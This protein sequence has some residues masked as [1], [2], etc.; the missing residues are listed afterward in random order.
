MLGILGVGA[1]QRPSQA[2]ADQG[3]FA[4]AGSGCGVFA[5]VESVAPALVCGASA[6]RSF[7]SAA[8]AGATPACIVGIVAKAGF[9]RVTLWLSTQ[10]FMRAPGRE[11]GSGVDLT[12]GGRLVR[13]WTAMETARHPFPVSSTACTIG[14]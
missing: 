14:E 13:A 7:S 5:R 11:A 10:V 2:Q 3:F 4:E 12:G 1:L 9:V 8:S 6:V